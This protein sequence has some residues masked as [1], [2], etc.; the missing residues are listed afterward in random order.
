MMKNLNYL[1]H[2]GIDFYFN[3]SPRT[4]V[5][6]EIPLYSFSGSGEHL[7]LKIRKKGLSTLEMLNI[8]S[9]NLNIKKSEIGYA[10]LKDKEALSI[11][12]ISINKKLAKD[13]EKLDLP[14]IKILDSTYHNN[15]IKL[16]H[17]KGNKFYICIKKLNA[18]NAKKI[19][20]VCK[21]LAKDGMPN[22]FGFQR[23]GKFGD[24]YKEGRAILEGKLKLRDKKIS[25]FLISAYQSYLFNSWLSKRIELS[26]IIESFSIPEASRLLKLESSYIKELKSQRHFFKI[27]RG[28]VMGHYP[29]GKL[30][31]AQDSVESKI[32]SSMQDSI[33]LDS[34]ALESSLDF[35]S[36]DSINSINLD[37]TPQDSTLLDSTSLDSKNATLDIA[38]LDLRFY[39][40]SIAPTGLL[41]GGKALRARDLALEIEREFIDENLK[42]EIGD[43]RFA[44]VFIENLEFRY[45][46][47]VANGEFNFYLPKGSYASTFLEILSN[48]EDVCQS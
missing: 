21:I 2:F 9:K 8:I 37:L 35:A 7:I 15:K 6:E 47:E 42:G 27:L 22:Y 19:S 28:D 43:R 24:N 34:R 38:P 45:K 41:C 10:G 5:V 44:W 14:N 25:K 46:S 39:N 36:L 18:I 16:G 17:L 26:R 1:S 31:Y 40:H 20:E 3:K 12:Y 13:I 29:N 32:D 11:Q 4:F 48:K 33:N 30:F 23:F